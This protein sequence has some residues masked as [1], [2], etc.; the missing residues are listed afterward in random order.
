MTAPLKESLRDQIRVYWASDTSLS[1]EEVAARYACS[2][3][4]VRGAV[5]DLP[6][7]G[8]R[9]AR[10][11]IGQFGVAVRDGKCPP[12]SLRVLTAITAFVDAH[13]FAPTTRQLC[14]LLN[15]TST[16]GVHEHLEYLV[17]AKLITRR[18]KQ[19]RTIVVTMKGREALGQP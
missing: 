15:V 18:A 4:Q 16:N 3:R 9:A 2:P 12:A 1:Y 6:R 8:A 11:Q 10:E 5:A 7:E 17:A 13:G 19:S 14:Q